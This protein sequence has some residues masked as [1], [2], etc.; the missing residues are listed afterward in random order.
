MVWVESNGAIC[1]L[2]TFLFWILASLFHVI[3]HGR[4]KSKYA[5]RMDSC[6]GLQATW[7]ISLLAWGG[8]ARVVMILL[9]AEFSRVQEEDS[10]VDERNYCRSLDHCFCRLASRRRWERSWGMALSRPTTIRMGS[11]VTNPT[12]LKKRSTHIRKP[13]PRIT[14]SMISAPLTTSGVLDELVAGMLTASVLI[15]GGGVHVPAECVDELSL[16]TVDHSVSPSTRIGDSGSNTP[17]WI[18]ASSSRRPKG[19][20]GCCSAFE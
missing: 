20:T 10:S 16:L 13:R 17:A 19:P 9:L 6:G 1:P 2:L 7:T 14:Q 11:T 3:M 18:N 12:Q 8:K 4:T 15:R 5:F